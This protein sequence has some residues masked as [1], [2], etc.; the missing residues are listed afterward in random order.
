MPHA[1]CHISYRHIANTISL[2]R[3][4]GHLVML[5]AVLAALGLG[6]FA[7]KL[8]P[9]PQVEVHRAV[10]ETNVLLPFRLSI[11]VWTSL[12]HL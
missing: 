8:L 2:I 3:Q 4:A 6:A 5:R 1:T 10:G 7:V 9:A 12:T 11:Y